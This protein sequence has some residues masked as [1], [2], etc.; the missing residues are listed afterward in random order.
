MIDYTKND[1]WAVGL[2]GYQLL[3]GRD[4]SPYGGQGDNADETWKAIPAAC[5]AGYSAGA[6]C[7]AI[8]RGLLHLDPVERL[9]VGK[10]RAKILASRRTRFRK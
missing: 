10:A 9:S 7:R 8:V 2:I 5:T 3:C 6:T 4:E 1:D